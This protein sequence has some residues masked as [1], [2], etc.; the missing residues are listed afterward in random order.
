MANYFSQEA[1]QIY[2]DTKSEPAFFDTI[3]EAFDAIHKNTVS[4]VLF[5]AFNDSGIV[6]AVEM[7]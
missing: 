6:R 2:D 5:L 4:G 1:L 7:S 3:S